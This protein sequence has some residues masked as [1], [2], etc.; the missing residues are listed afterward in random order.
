MFCDVF[1][2]V[3]VYLVGFTSYVKAGYAPP[4]VN[5]SSVTCGITCT[6]GDCPG[7][8]GDDIIC[9]SEYADTIFAGKGDDQ[10]CAGD[11]NDV[12]HGGFGDDAIDGEG[13]D[14]TIHGGWGDDNMVGGEGDDT[15][16]AG[17]CNDEVN[18]GEGDEY[19][20]DTCLGGLGSDYFTVD[21]CE[22]ADLGQQ[23]VDMHD[24]CNLL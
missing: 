13:D 22:N 6:G 20:G 18:G 19:A 21:S 5:C 2:F 4:P 8:E 17:R 9:G 15:I 1:W 16:L 12:I 14:E 23:A 3:C 11:G 10:V 7:T 24:N